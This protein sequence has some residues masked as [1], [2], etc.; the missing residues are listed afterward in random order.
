[1]LAF[2]VECLLLLIGWVI[3][4]GRRKVVKESWR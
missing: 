4:G 2:V 3:L 1:V